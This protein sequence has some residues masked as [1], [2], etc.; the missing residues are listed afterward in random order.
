MR[1]EYTM[2]RYGPP[3]ENIIFF[4]FASQRFS[5]NNSASNY[6]KEDAI[7]CL[8]D[9][10]HDKTSTEIATNNNVVKDENSLDY[11]G[12]RPSAAS[13]VHHIVVPRN[14]WLHIIPTI[15]LT[16]WLI[17]WLHFTVTALPRSS[18]ER[19]ANFLHKSAPNTLDKIRNNLPKHERLISNVERPTQWIVKSGCHFSCMEQSSGIQ[20][21]SSVKDRSMNIQLCQAQIDVSSKL[22]TRHLDYI[23]FDFRHVINCKRHESSRQN[24]VKI[25]NRRCADWAAVECK[26]HRVQ[27]IRTGDAKWP[28]KTSTLLIDSIW[29]TANRDTFRLERNAR[30]RT[31][32]DTV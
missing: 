29:S 22:T 4:H 24:C 8:K 6:F 3:G 1:S 13:L 23:A 15:L 25:I 14:G 10:S 7:F 27:T 11:K 2:F 31:T 26:F 5:C 16:D 18:I 20:V 32:I 17:D 9:R 21:V 12:L 19:H 30:A 28:V